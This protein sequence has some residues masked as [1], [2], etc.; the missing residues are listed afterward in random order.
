MKLV[1]MSKGL[2]LGYL[3][4][5]CTNALL[6]ILFSILIIFLGALTSMLLFTYQNTLKIVEQN[7]QVATD[8]N[9]IAL[10]NQVINQETL[11]L[12]REVPLQN[13][14]ILEDVQG[15]VVFLGSNFNKSFIEGIYQD[16]LTTNKTLQSILENQRLLAS[17]VNATTDLFGTASHFT[18]PGLR[19]ALY[20]A[21]ATSETNNTPSMN[22]E[23]ES[24]LST[25]NQSQN[26][27]MQLREQVQNLSQQAALQQQNNTSFETTFPFAQNRIERAQAP[28]D[29]YTELKE[30]TIAG[31]PI[32]KPESN[33]SK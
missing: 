11:N 4:R 10:Q 33:S 27:I 3:N 15:I 20:S 32:Q 19:N 13:R 23:L 12:T 31:L 9:Q 22:T 7:N 2:G 1:E 16:R 21:A 5:F 24:L 8:N 25:L 30:G 18:P 28:N 26:T 17:H 14:K 6:L 29:T